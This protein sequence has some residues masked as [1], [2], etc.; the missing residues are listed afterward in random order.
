VEALALLLRVVQIKSSAGD[1]VVNVPLATVLP[2]HAI[3]KLAFYVFGKR[4]VGTTNKRLCTRAL[5]VA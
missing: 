5:V 3:C 4:I 2:R 1:D